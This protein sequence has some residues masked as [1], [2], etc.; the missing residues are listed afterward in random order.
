MSVV[1]ATVLVAATTVV[2]CSSDS[3]T[4]EVAETQEKVTDIQDQPGSVDGYVGASK[5]AKVETCDL[6]GG[7]L[8]VEGT[9]KN[10]ESDAQDY[11][12]YVSALENSDT[13]GLVQVDV[14]DVA[15]GKSV[16]W[17]TDI[18]YKAD[19]LECVLR[20]ERFDAE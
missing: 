17:S 10:P 4:E 15:P 13:V 2:G 20:V 14:T 7:S 8:R 5:D 3:D 16:E 9:V 1:A 11:R 6:Q 19:D 18:D 12:L